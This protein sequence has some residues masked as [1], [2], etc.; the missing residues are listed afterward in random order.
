MNP[1]I[2]KK[3]GKIKCHVCYDEFF[4]IYGIR[5]KKDMTYTKTFFYC[6]ALNKYAILNC[7]PTY[8]IYEIKKGKWKLVKR[9]RMWWKLFKSKYIDNELKKRKPVVECPF[10]IEHLITELNEK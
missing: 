3:C 9:T 5:V 8:E 7:Y 10:Y 6:E 1:D 2:C 4:I